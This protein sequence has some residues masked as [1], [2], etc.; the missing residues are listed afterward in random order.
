MCV[1]IDLFGTQKD[2]FKAICRYESENLLSIPRLTSRLDSAMS[3]MSGFSQEDIIDLTTPRTPLPDSTLQDGVVH[4]RE[5]DDS[6]HVAEA[7]SSPEPAF[8][9]PTASNTR[10]TSDN[11]VY[12]SPSQAPVPPKASSQSIYLRVMGRKPGTSTSDVQSSKPFK[13]T[14][15]NYSIMGLFSKES[16]EVGGDIYTFKSN[17]FRCFDMW[18][19]F[20]VY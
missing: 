16:N 17:K 3:N 10:V 8:F 19:C 15:I 13:A 11:G 14:P 6:A 5:E 4:E 12:A 20:F 1:L 18:H 9:S 7:I 2:L